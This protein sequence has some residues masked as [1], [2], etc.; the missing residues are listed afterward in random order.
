MS[1][2]DRPLT[3]PQSDA[4]GSPAEHLVLLEQYRSLNAAAQAILTPPVSAEE[5]G[6]L[7]TH[8][9]TGMRDNDFEEE[10]DECWNVFERSVQNSVVPEVTEDEWDS[11]WLTIL[12]SIGHPADEKPFEVSPEMVGAYLDG[13]L[14]PEHA[15]LIDAAFSALTSEIDSFAQSE[16]VPA[17]S[18][19]EWDLQSQNVAKAMEPTIETSNME[20]RLNAYHDGELDAEGRAE[21]EAWLEG[22]PENRENLREIERLDAMAR[23]DK[24]PTV[25]KEE[26]GSRS[27]VFM[28]ESPPLS[29]VHRPIWVTAGLW[30]ASVAAGLAAIIWAA[31]LFRPEPTQSFAWQTNY[32][33]SALEIDASRGNA[34]VYYSEEADLTIIWQ[35]SD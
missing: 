4:G 18:S 27:K 3:G 8:I 15:E 1:T 14:D 5:W 12:H 2:E 29:K 23:L 28:E 16:S 30:A 13:E 35:T 17:V 19:E 33:S 25:S 26:W 7:W 22:H 11:R 20:V 10:I 21:V 24:V 9:R 32:E 34:F 31:N 6:N